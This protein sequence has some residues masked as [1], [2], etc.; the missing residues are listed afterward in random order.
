MVC[1]VTSYSFVNGSNGAEEPPPFALRIEVY[2]LK[3]Y[4]ESSFTTLVH[5]VGLDN[6]NLLINPA[7]ITLNGNKLQ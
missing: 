6:W 7:E 4:V 1:D 5:N 3:K 2:A